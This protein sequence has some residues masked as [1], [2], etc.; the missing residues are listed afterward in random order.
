MYWQ[1]ELE[2]CFLGEVWLLFQWHLR[3]KEANSANAEEAV[4]FRCIDEG[5]QLPPY[6][7][8]PLA[9]NNMSQFHS[10]VGP[11]VGSV[12]TGTTVIRRVYN[13]LRWCFVAAESHV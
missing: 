7:A 3:C 12:S 2:H 10:S 1:S 11:I 9:V 5:R 8:L 4:V 13:K 6:A